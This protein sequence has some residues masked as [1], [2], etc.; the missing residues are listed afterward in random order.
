MFNHFE[1]HRE[2]SIKSSLLTNLEEYGEVIL[3]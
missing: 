3:K 1:T 2:L